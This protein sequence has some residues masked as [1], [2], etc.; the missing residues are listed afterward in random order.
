VWTAEIG[1]SYRAIGRRHAEDLYWF[2]K[3][4]VILVRFRRIQR[5]A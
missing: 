4:L 3:I 5:R 1:R 2:C